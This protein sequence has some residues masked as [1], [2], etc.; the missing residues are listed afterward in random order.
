MITVSFESKGKA[1]VSC[2]GM[3]LKCG[4]MKLRYRR[5]PTW[6]YDTLNLNFSPSEELSSDP[7]RIAAPSGRQAEA[8][9]RFTLEK[10]CVK[11]LKS[12]HVWLRLLSWASKDTNWNQRS[13]EVEALPPPTV[14]VDIFLHG[15]HWGGLRSKNKLLQLNKYSLLMKLS[16]KKCPTNL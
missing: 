6:I 11:R 1:S 13:S 7:P 16:L 10:W 5:I 3:F 8:N 9:S 12:E 15:E 14:I 4:L 2:T